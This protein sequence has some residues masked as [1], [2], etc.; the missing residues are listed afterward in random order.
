MADVIDPSRTTYR[1]VHNPHSGNA[2]R[3]AK[4]RAAVESFIQRENLRADLVETF[5]PTHATHLSRQAVADGCDV[6]VA[7]GGDG[8]MNEVAQAVAHS[9][10]VFGLIPGGSG[11]GLG[12]HLGLQ[13]SIPQALT[14]LINGRI[15]SI[16]TG[17]ANRQPFFN[18][19]GIGYDAELSVMFN[20]LTR[21]GLWPYLREGLKLW[22]SYRPAEYTVHGPGGTLTIEALMVAVANSD[23][24]GYNCFISPGAEVDDSLLNLVLVKPV[25]ALQFVPLAYRMRCGTADKS[26][27]VKLLSGDRFLIETNVSSP[28]HTD[29]EVHEP[30]SRVEVGVRPQSLR[31]LVPA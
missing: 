3:N 24:Y 25:S 2:S 15:R 16:D 27:H 14:T 28:I 19:M 5:H 20:R 11:N 10:A 22:R 21:R 30:T 26:P 23:Q 4:I 9:D 31:M 18:I 12:R 29:G 13:G 7:M 17:E 8:T 1:F 6:I